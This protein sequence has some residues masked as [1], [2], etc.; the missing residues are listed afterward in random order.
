MATLALV[1]ALAGTGYAALA[2]PKHS[3]GTP[4]LKGRA[5]TNAKIVPGAGVSLLYTRASTTVSIA[6]GGV[7]GGYAVCRSGPTRSAAASGPT[8]SPASA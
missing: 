6:P 2:I 4:Q 1:V 7:G 5:V 3:V 8:A